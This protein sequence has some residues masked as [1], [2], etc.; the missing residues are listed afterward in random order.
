MIF[1][2]SKESGAVVFLE[3]H[4]RFFRKFEIGFNP[5]H[6]DAPRLPLW[7]DPAKQFSVYDAIKRQI[8]A[9]KALE[10]QA[11]GDIVELMDVEYRPAQKALVVLIHRAS[12]NA[13]DPSYRK[14]AR[15]AAGKKVQL[16]HAEKGDDEEQS[17]SAHLVI[18]DL[19]LKS[20]AR[21]AALEE[22]PGISMACVRRLVAVAM[23][24]YTYPFNRGKKQIETSSSFSPQ[25]VKSETMT[26]AL[27]KGHLGFVTLSRPGKPDFVDA[28]GLFKPEREV[29]R[30]RVKGEVDQSNWKKIFSDL[31]T[32]AKEKGWDDF[33]VDINL[34]DNRS[35]TVKIDREDEA[36]E[37]LFVRSEQASFKTALRSCSDSVVDEVI[38]KALTI[39]KSN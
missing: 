37:I 27:K 23:G 33:K 10:V 29:L 8:D 39:A 18:A 19:T 20:G 22:I 15:T 17:V 2:A 6:R 34:D 38:E 36:S 5:R 25:G 3:K 4:S 30:L 21:P 32:N 24:E 11:N 16:R 9:E 12:P 14:K 26:N 7:E 35:R 31:V 28:A 13:A 1:I